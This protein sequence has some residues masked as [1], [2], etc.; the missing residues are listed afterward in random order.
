MRDPYAAHRD[1]DDI[2][3]LPDVNKHT[4]WTEWDY[5]LAEAYTTRENFTDPHTG[6]PRWL[7]EDPDVYWDIGE[8]VSHAAADLQRAQEEVHDRPG[9]DVFLKNP[10]KTTGEF[11]TIDDWLEQLES[12]SR[13]MERG[14]PEG[15]TGPSAEDL[16][17]LMERRRKVIEGN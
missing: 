11:W 2:Y 3:W 9:W 4:Q 7:A 14:A 6:Q 5:A 15:A 10:H 12:D 1:Y 13:V 8:T 17:A 16:A